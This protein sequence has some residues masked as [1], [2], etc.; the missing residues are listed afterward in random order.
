MHE[1]FNA[2]RFGGALSPIK[3]RI[4]HKMRRR[5]GE[6]AVD[7]DT[8]ATEIAISVR[9]LRRDGRGEIEHTVLHEMVHQWQSESGL[10]IDHGPTFRRKAVEVG[11]VPR[12]DRL[13]GTEAAV[14]TN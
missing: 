10:A 2:E 5:L 11:V 7:P 9:H 6:L 8:H 13:V 12:A 1:R 3:F 4:S 14:C